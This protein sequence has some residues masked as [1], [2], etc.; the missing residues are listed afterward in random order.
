MP[1][2][3]QCKIKSFSAAGLL[4]YSAA[5]LLSFLQ[6]D[7]CGNLTQ[8]AIQCMSKSLSAAVFC[9]IAQRVLCPSKNLMPAAI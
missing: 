5:G 7:A 9:L 1:L 2:A 8:L 3:I 4:S 6:F